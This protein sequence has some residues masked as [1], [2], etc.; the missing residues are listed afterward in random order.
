MHGLLKNRKVEYT[1]IKRNYKSRIDRIYVNE[2]AKS[3][4]N[5]KTI[6][7]NLSDHSCVSATINIQG[8]PKYGKGYWKLNT[9]LLEDSVIKAKSANLWNKLKLEI[10]NY[11][12][13]NIW[14]E[15]FV[16]EKV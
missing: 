10:P 6:H 15:S 7:T 8:M 1:Y 9:S 11:Q 16:K 2:L 13:I 4:S 3:I 5:V 14:W 12:N